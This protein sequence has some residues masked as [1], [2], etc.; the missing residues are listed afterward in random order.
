MLSE[1]TQNV[2]K[3]REVR[4]LADNASLFELVPKGQFPMHICLQTNNLITVICLG[5]VSPKPAAS[6]PPS[7][8]CMLTVMLLCAATG[9]AINPLDTL[10]ISPRSAGSAHVSAERAKEKVWQRSE[11]GFVFVSSISSSPPP[12][13]R[14]SGRS[15]PS[16]GKRTRQMIL[17]KPRQV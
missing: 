17:I 8:L 3:R 15:D 10:Q 6:R 14:R 2:I 12:A 9:V 16:L 1:Q 7:L 4:Y 13:F 5:K 11:W